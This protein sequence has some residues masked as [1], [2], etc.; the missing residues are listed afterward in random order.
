MWLDFLNSSFFILVYYLILIFFIGLG[1][2]IANR[3]KKKSKWESSGIENA[4]IGIFALIISFT[5]LQ[6]GNAHKDRSANI[7]SEANYI[8]MLYRYS[9]EMPDTFYRYTRNEIATL[10]KNQLAYEKTNDEQFF[11]KSKVASDSYWT[12]LRKFKEGGSDSVNAST[13]NKISECFDQI[14][15]AVSLN[16][17]SFYE[18]TPSLVMFLLVT[19]SLLIGFLV[20]FMNG[21]KPKIHFLVPFIYF[22]LIAITMAVISDLN[23][24]RLGL[25]K[26]SYHHLQKTFEYINNDQRY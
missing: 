2:F 25:I 22:V 23:N 20:G 15:A 16:A 1:I 19:G 9:K 4:I 18:R 21:I 24:P 12:R 10:L 6:A 11:Y 17:Y 14:Q 13:V 8:E 5:F 3:L 7:H 26:P